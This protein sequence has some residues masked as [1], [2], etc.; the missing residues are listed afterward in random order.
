METI[1]NQIFEIYLV[2]KHDSCDWDEQL[3]ILNKDDAISYSCKYKNIRVEIF[4]KS[5]NDN[6]YI[7]TY[8]YYRGGILYENI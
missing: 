1:I 7:P 8:S 6:T 5:E 4:Q 3:I 2:I